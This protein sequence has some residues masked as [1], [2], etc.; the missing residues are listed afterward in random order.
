[1]EVRGS[2]VG[3]G[4][5]N[6]SFWEVTVEEKGGAPC[7][8]GSTMDVSFA[9]ARGDLKLSAIRTAGDIVYL[10]PGPTPSS[11]RFSH[12]ASGEIDTFPCVVPPIAR[13]AISPASSLGSLTVNPGPAGGWGTP[14][15]GSS[16]SYLAE[17]WSDNCCM[18][19]AASTQTSIDAPPLVHPGDHVRFLVT[20]KNQPVP[21]S[22]LFSAEPQPQLWSFSP[23][24][25][26]HQELEGVSGT[27][28]SYLLN[29]GQAAPIPANGSATFEMY[30]D[31][32]G[33][34]HPGPAVLVWSIDGSP[35][36]YQTAR[37]NVEIVPR[38][39]P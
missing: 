33:G 31:V 8:V 27:F 18:G 10:A 14:C 11:S 15:P 34:T 22:E 38:A 13:M 19:Y 32:P 12:Q 35:S 9:T 2:Y 39:T 28:H 17:L 4:P 37:T 26:Y 1:V 24:P 23:C 30:M 25:T 6:T 29:C 5:L 20:L 36:R 21:H 16:G 3:G 7:F